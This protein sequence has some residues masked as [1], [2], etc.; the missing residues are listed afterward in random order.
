MGVP[1]FDR[2]GQPIARPNF[3]PPD[4]ESIA[5][6]KLDARALGALEGLP[7]RAQVAQQ[8]GFG[9]KKKKY[10]EQA[11]KAR[12]ELGI[13]EDRVAVLSI[14]GGGARG[15]I[16][17]AMLAKFE[18]LHAPCAQLFDI[19]CGTSTGAIIGSL[20]AAGMRAE[21]IRKL[22]LDHLHEIFT[23]HRDGPACG[24][25]QDRW[26]VSFP[27]FAAQQPF[28]D[29]LDIISAVDPALG[30]ALDALQGARDKLRRKLR[31]KVESF[32]LSP[33][34]HALDAHIT[35]RTLRLVSGGPAY[36]KEAK[37]LPLMREAFEQSRCSTMRDLARR[38]DCVLVFTAVD[39]QS[40]ATVYMSAS[41]KDFRGTCEDAKVV[42]CIEASMSG[43]LYFESFKGELV[44]GGTLSAN[45]PLLGALLHLE[46]MSLAQVD[47][48]TPRELTRRAG[49]NG[50]KTAGERLRAEFGTT[51]APV[52]QTFDLHNTTLISLGC[53]VGPVKPLRESILDIS[54]SQI[55]YHEKRWP[56]GELGRAM[57]LMAQ[58]PGGVEDAVT[59]AAVL[60]SSTVAGGVAAGPAGL[61]VGALIGLVAGSLAGG[62]SAVEYGERWLSFGGNMKETL[63][64]HHLFGTGYLANTLGFLKDGLGRNAWTTQEE[65][66]RSG[67]YR[68][69]FRRFQLSLDK[70][71][72]CDGFWRYSTNREAAQNEHKM[73]WT[74][75]VGGEEPVSGAYTLVSIWSEISAP[76]AVFTAI[77]IPVE[78]T[79]QGVDPDRFIPGTDPMGTLGLRWLYCIGQRLVL[80][81]REFEATKGAGTVFMAHDLV[82]DEG[83]DAFVSA[84]CRDY[85]PANRWSEL[86]VKLNNL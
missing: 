81:T 60:A 1:F 34:Y 3:P 2:S 25:Y 73:P 17:L 61:A 71:M 55:H 44:D 85:V 67:L 30:A 23:L 75:N 83:H 11:R 63:D 35:D 28:D 39:Y 82:D 41:G 76:K 69:D 62:A 8:N 54:K 42:N 29:V 48:E 27:D 7:F 50:G 53:G 72:Q 74:I 36:D 66:F 19:I 21:Q 9:F 51:E 77:N 43:P 59:G 4:R 15:L 13:P 24:P 64:G 47:A 10:S 38:S 46:R 18:A 20:L 14:D 68:G 79:I 33:A 5:Q 45:M 32:K 52:I 57:E 26:E 86:T 80:A 58:L 78:Q 37:L 40:G 84:R 16:P 70:D 22:Y 31:D 6:F 49:R 12:Q 65:V 56:Y